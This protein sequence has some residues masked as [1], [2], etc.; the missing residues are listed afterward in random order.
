MIIC[1][2]SHMGVPRLLKG[3][4]SLQLTHRGACGLNA[5][6]MSDDDLHNAHTRVE[7]TPYGHIEC[8]DRARVDMQMLSPRP[9]Q[10]M[11]SEETRSSFTH[12]LQRPTTFLRARFSCNRIDSP[13]SAACRKRVTARSR[14]YLMKWNAV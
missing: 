7:M 2:H 10:K 8:L 11:Y 13:A 5:R 1:C 4:R 6:M 9:F 12:T 14:M 3:F